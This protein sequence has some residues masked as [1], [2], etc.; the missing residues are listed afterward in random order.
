MK[1][2]L[3]AVLTLSS[4]G[5]IFAFI[6]GYASR[7]FD[8]KIDPIVE[9]VR[10]VLPGANCGACGFPGCDGFANALVFNNASVNACPVGGQ[11]LSKEL[12]RILGKEAG[13]FERNVAVVLCQGS[14]SV[15][16][17]KYIYEGV[18]DCRVA[19]LFQKGEKSC[20]YGC[21][22]CGTCKEVCNYNAIEMRDGVAHII[23][24]NC[25]ACRKCIDIC[26]KGIIEMVPYEQKVFVKCKSIDSGK[27]TKSSCSRGCIGCK[28]CTRQYPEGFVIENNLAKYINPEIV[29]EEALENAIKKCPVKAITSDDYKKESLN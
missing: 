5:I 12:S 18:S 21:L 9:E 15:A 4:L 22:G 2:I 6:L 29:N 20:T 13:K 16:K 8:I 25:V 23:K 28:I 26:P 24:E 11:T 14:C 17:N 3:I 1:D 27:I 19:A 10:S 7:V